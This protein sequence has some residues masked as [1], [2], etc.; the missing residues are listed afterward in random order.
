MTASPSTTAGSTQMRVR[1]QIH[2]DRHGTVAELQAIRPSD[3]TNEWVAALSS[4][5]IPLDGPDWQIA[6]DPSNSGRQTGWFES[7]AGG[8]SPNESSLG[9]PRCLPRLSRRRLVL[10]GVRRAGESIVQT[11]GRSCGSNAVDYL[12]EVWVNGQRVGG[13]EGGETPLELDVTS[14]IRAGTGT[15]WRCVC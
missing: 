4:R 6:I 9:D 8:D 15:C 11:G 12:A 13:H 10:E 14:A 1:L 5:R 2:L 7:T 3:C